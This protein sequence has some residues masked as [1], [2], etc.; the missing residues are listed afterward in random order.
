MSRPVTIDIPHA[1]GAADSRPC[2][3]VMVFDREARRAHPG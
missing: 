1:L 3:V 2:E